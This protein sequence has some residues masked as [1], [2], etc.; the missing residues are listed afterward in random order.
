MI[1]HTVF[2][3][4]ASSRSCP[5]SPLA[6]LPQL[7]SRQ[8]E[9]GF[10]INVV[11]PAHSLQPDAQTQVPKFDYDRALSDHSGGFPYHAPIAEDRSHDF[12]LFTRQSLIALGRS[13]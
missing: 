8:A 7:F 11:C 1:C 10:I 3:D 4:L 6:Q 2:I 12:A 13:L 9:Y 5:S